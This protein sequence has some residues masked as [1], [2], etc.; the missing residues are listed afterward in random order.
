M[1]FQ[2]RLCRV[3]IGLTY[4]SGLRVWPYEAE[5]FS[6]ANGSDHISAELH[7]DG[8]KDCKDGSDEVGCNEVKDRSSYTHLE[9]KMLETDKSRLDKEHYKWFWETYKPTPVDTA[10]VPGHS[11]HTVEMWKL[12]APHSNPKLATMG[13]KHEG[14]GFLLK[15]VEGLE[16][17]RLAYQYWSASPTAFNER[18]PPL[19]L[20]TDG[21]LT[22]DEKGRLGYNSRAVVTYSRSRDNWEGGY[23]KDNM[24][25]T[26]LTKDQY[27]DVGSFIEQWH[28]KNQQ[29]V[30]TGFLYNLHS[31]K[32]ISHHPKFMHRMWAPPKNAM[33]VCFKQMSRANWKEI[34]SV[35]MEEHACLDFNIDVVHHASGIDLMTDKG[36]TFRDWRVV[37]PVELNAPAIRVQELLQ[38]GKLATKWG[39]NDDSEGLIAIPAWFDDNAKPLEQGDFVEKVHIVK[40]LLISVGGNNDAAAAMMPQCQKWGEDGDCPELTELARKYM[41]L[42]K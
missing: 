19:L 5:P 34:G 28:E 6:C 11:V 39:K 40:P 4:V 15:D 2:M 13:W 8:T 33:N 1:T 32:D 26:S 22:Y 25:L 18:L 16:L 29:F 38:Q 30:P 20:H 9:Y 17:G 35:L 37:E 24:F 12:A 7:C 27:S 41:G 36:A 31:W 23:W 14:I 21:N 42:F 10:P 3:V